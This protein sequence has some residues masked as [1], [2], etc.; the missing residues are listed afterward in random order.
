MIDFTNLMELTLGNYSYATSKL[1]KC[2]NDDP[3]SQ[4]FKGYDNIEEI[5]YL[6][7]TKS[8]YHEEFVDNDSLDSTDKMLG[9]KV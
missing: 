4:L 3:Y 7:P 6:N 1:I 8:P 5:Q 9:M 2:K